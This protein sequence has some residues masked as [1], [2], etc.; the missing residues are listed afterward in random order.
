MKVL[1]YVISLLALAVGIILAVE[2]PN[3]NR[4]STIAGLLTGVGFS[5]NIVAF[6]LTQINFKQK[7][8]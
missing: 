7:K 2:Y 6:V 1:I 4:L 8:T 3:S 5:L